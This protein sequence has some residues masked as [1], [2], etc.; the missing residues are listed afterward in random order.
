M[1]TPSTTFAIC[2]CVG[3]LVH[4]G[5]E[6]SQRT[7][8]QHTAEPREAVDAVSENVTAVAAI[9]RA[10]GKVMR[11]PKSGR[12]VGVDLAQGRTSVE[13]ATLTAALSLPN[14]TTLRVVGGSLSREVL[15]NIASQNSLEELLLTATPTTDSDV[16]ELLA[17]LPRLQRITLRRLTQVTDAS[18]VAIANH[19]SLRNVALL[20]LPITRASLETLAKSE[21][22]TA[23]DLRGCPQLTSDDYTA[24]GAMTRLTQLKIGSPLVDDTVLER[25]SSLPHLT[26]L[27]IE[28]ASI[29]ADGLARLLNDESFASRLTSLGLARMWAIDDATLT[30]LRSA[31]NLRTLNLRDI[32][33]TGAFLE[34]L[35]HEKLETLF[36]DK[37]FLRREVFTTLA[38]FSSLKRLSLMR[39]HVTRDDVALLATLPQLESLALA[40]CQLTDDTLV[41]LV[42]F[43]KLTTIDVSANPSL[44][45]AAVKAFPT[46]LNER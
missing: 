43:P 33:V 21:S 32:A 6:P 13:D 46:S 7:L 1:R 9:E 44:T 19:G 24:V 4:V 22:I 3:M 15:A 2:L 12:I 14:L 35:S 30:N 20:E 10:G 17:R 8:T 39:A 42:D 28:D 25:L 36:L 45:P 31:K 41:P 5:C 38:K 37:A 26:G 23:L 16:A 34:S 11:S 29:T 40:E 18:A 27:A